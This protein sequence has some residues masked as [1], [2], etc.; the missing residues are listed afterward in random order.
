MPLISPIVA[1]ILMDSIIGSIM[2]SELLQMFLKLSSD[3][4]NLSMSRFDLKVESVFNCESDF[5]YPI[6]NPN[7]VFFQYLNI[8][9]I[10]L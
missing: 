5:V 9:L 4:C 7:V 6:L 8:Y 1:P 2:F 10:L 3:D